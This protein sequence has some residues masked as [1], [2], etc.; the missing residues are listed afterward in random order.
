M[1]NSEKHKSQLL[2]YAISSEGKI[3]HVDE[4]PNGNK[5]GCVCP[6]CKENLIAKNQGKTDR[7]HHFAHQSGTECDYAVES[8][9]HLLAKEKIRET[10]LSSDEFWIGFGYNSYCSCLENCEYNHYGECSEY[11]VKRFDLKKFYDSCEQEKPYENINRRSDL[12]LFSSTNP[13]RSP[14]YL[15][16]CVTHA[17]D[18]AKL[19][20]DNKIIEIVIESEKDVY[21]IIEH[22]LIE[23]SKISFYGFKN[24]DYNNSRMGSDIEFIRYMLFQSGKSYSIQDSCNCKQLKKKDIS[25]FEMCFH[26]SQSYC[27][28]VHKY[29]KYKGYE[30]Y[31]IKNCSVCKN[32]VSCYNGDGYICR[33]YKYLGISRYEPFDTSRAR[34][35]HRFDLNKEEMEEELRKGCN[36]KYLILE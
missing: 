14:I 36:C 11:K 31:R 28:D 4:V 27:M 25:L 13:N 16:F 24:S 2:T 8:M 6:S 18:E 3:V 21:N 29:A 33:L 9:L 30:K 20:S 15:E 34:T 12:K 32:Y 17:S 23:R 26:T 7:K 1:T 19:H 5:C 35:C 10:F 22:G